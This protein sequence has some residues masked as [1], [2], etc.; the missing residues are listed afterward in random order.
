MHYNY[1]E[2]GIA[3]KRRKRRKRIQLTDKS[4]SWT[5]VCSPSPRPSPQGRG[6][7]I[8]RFLEN[9]SAAFPA[10]AWNNANL[11][12]LF[13]LPEGEGKGEGESLVGLPRT[14][15][16]P[17]A[18]L[19]CLFVAQDFCVLSYSQNSMRGSPPERIG[20]SRPAGQEIVRR[21]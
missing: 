19:V 6:W 7:T 8:L 3:A 17:T 12:T 13:P 5:T 10:M 18:C 20:C 11:R 15:A 14:V 2:A 1:E 21:C 9:P 4:V 16:H